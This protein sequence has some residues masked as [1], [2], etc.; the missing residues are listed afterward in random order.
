MIYANSNVQFSGYGLSP[1]A[2]VASMVCAVA[3]LTGGLQVA[4]AVV[5]AVSQ[6][7]TVV[8]QY[9]GDALAGRKALFAKRVSG[10]VRRAD[11]LPGMSVAFGRGRVALLLFVAPGFLPGV[12]V[13]Q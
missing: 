1:A 10:Q 5:A 11:N 9:G 4:L 2:A 3:K 7:D 8:H 6:W 12:G 13:S